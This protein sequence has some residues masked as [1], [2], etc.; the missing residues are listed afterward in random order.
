MAANAVLFDLFGTLIAPY[1]Y[2]EHQ[3]WV[4]GAAALLG[5]EP[6]ECT[7]HWQRTWQRRAR[8]EFRS[9]EENLRVMAPRA[10]APQL[11]AA[12]RA[13]S[14]FTWESLKPKAGALELLDRL[15]ERGVRLALVSNCAADLPLLWPST[16]FAAR[17]DTSVFSCDIG[18]MKPRPEIYQLALERLGVAPVNACFVGDGSDNE[19]SAARKIGLTPILVDNDLTNTY[20]AVRPDVAAWD[21]MRVRD[22]LGL[23]PLLERWRSFG[24]GRDEAWGKG[25]ALQKGRPKC[26]SPRSS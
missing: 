6:E 5:V 22:L 24:I 8:G 20:D 12:A 3:A 15:R 23:F 17:F 14:Q 26:P 21:G 16:P 9:I 7:H 10:T 19:L 25:A 13:Y 2:R 4:V 11:R 18:W 1:R